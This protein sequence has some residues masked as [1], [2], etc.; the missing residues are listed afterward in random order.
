M[1]MHPARVRRGIALVRPRA[2]KN[3]HVGVAPR[4]TAEGESQPPAKVNPLKP[5]R[6]L[7][8]GD[9]VQGSGVARQRRASTSVRQRRSETLKLCTTALSCDPRRSV[10]QP[11]SQTLSLSLGASQI[12]RAPDRKSVRVKLCTTALSCDPAETSTPTIEFRTQRSDF[13]TNDPTSD[14]KLCTTALSC[15]PRRDFKPN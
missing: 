15:A 7:T 11:L 3:G 10:T 1:M 4:Q 9:A 6:Q 12:V 13:N 14:P 2:E 8:F 5:Q